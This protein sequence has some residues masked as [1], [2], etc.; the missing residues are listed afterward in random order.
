MAPF[1]APRREHSA[2][3]FRLHARAETVRLGATTASR[4]IGALWQ[5]NPPL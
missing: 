3:A 2:A 4:L 1:L 5:S